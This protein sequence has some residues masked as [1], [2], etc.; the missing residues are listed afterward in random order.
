MHGVLRSNET[1]FTVIGG[2]GSSRMMVFSYRAMRANTSV[3]RT[4]DLRKLA[5]QKWPT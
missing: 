2:L 3:R 4:R 5:L 1:T